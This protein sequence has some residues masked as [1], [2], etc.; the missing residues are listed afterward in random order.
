MAGD[1]PLDA[2]A[3][4]FRPV[5]PHVIVLFGVTGD[6]AK[7]KLLPGLMH[8]CEAGLMPDF[9]LVGATRRDLGDEDLRKMAREACEEFGT[10]RGDRGELGPF[11]GADRPRQHQRGRG[12]PGRRGRRLREG[13]RRR[14]APPPL[15]ERATHRGAAHRPPDRRG[16]LRR[17]GADHHGEAVRHGP[18]ERSGAQRE[19]ARGLRGEADL[20]HRPL[21]RQGGGAEHPRAALRQRALRA[22]LEPQPHRPR[23]DRRPRDPHSRGPRELLRGG[24][25]LPRHGRDAPLPDPRF[26]CDGAPDLSRPGLDHRR[27]EQG[28]PKPAPARPGA[29]RA[30]PVRGVHLT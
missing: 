2:E 28:V 21:P 3:A 16:R 15:P 14:P 24:R 6:L 7:R 11:R 26:R 29:G 19:A 17:A 30:R 23:P 10:G 27:E 12:R 25:S 13:P 18:R 22:D 9:R 8:L 4:A 5:D 20:P 1:Q